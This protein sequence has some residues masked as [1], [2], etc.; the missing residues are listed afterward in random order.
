MFYVYVIQETTTEKT[1]VGFS[2]NLKQRL[3]EHNSSRG[4]RSTKGGQWRLIYYEAFAS[5]A[6]ARLREKRLKQD[7]RARYQLYARLEN[8]FAGQK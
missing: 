5:S 8:S 7:G 2:S 6:D 3:E 1:Y 4:G